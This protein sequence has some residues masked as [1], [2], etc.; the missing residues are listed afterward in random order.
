M[1]TSYR[2]PYDAICS[3][4]RKF[5]PY[6]F[7]DIEAAHKICAA[8]V[9]VEQGVR[10]LAAK[11]PRGSLHVDASLLWSREG[12]LAVAQE[13]VAAWG[14]T[15]G[16]RGPLDLEGVVA[17]V[18]RLEPPP[19]GVFPVHA[20]RTL[21]HPQHNTGASSAEGKASCKELMAAL[22]K[23]SA[24]QGLHTRYVRLFGGNGERKIYR[25]EE[26]ARLQRQQQGGEEEEE[27]A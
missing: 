2:D 17:D 20:Q 11:A 9:Q 7:T 3:E 25:G 4:A 1:L 14:V 26:L 27:E 13:L 6:L 15:P 21:L 10:A 24:C 5:H 12:L 22:A 18:L 16:T 8:R 19:P 23:D